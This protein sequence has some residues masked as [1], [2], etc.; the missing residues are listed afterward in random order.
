MERR[1]GGAGGGRGVVSGSCIAVWMGHDPVAPKWIRHC[2]RNVHMNTS[3][4]S[5]ARTSL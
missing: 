4:L 3:L 5:A 2:I 1:G